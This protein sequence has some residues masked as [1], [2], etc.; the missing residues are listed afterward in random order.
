M[1]NEI[2]D[3]LNSVAGVRKDWIADYIE[4]AIADWI[5]DW[6]ALVT[7]VNTV[8]P[9]IS[10]N[11]YVGST[12]TS[13]TGTF[14]GGDL[15]YT[16]VWKR[17]GVAITGATASTYVLVTADLGTVTTVVVTATNNVGAITGTSLGTAA[18]IATPVNTVLPSISGTAQE[19]Q[20]LTAANGT[21]TGGGT[22][23]YVYAWLRDAV[24]ISGATAGTYVPV[25]ADVGTVITLRVT[26]TNAAGTGTPAVSVATATVI[27][28]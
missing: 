20:T 16:Y 26:A 6:T 17:G 2:R 7:P 11:A 12:L 15:T 13:T 28:A 24:V 18:V 21:W 8:V 25:L 23:S 3:L 4:D 27:A 14:T 5:V 1:A 19:G 10:G 22:I 9:V